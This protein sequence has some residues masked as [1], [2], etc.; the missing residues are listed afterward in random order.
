MLQKKN[1]EEAE[2]VYKVVFRYKQNRDRIWVLN[3]SL[4][5]WDYKLGKDGT[6]NNAGPVG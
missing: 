4:A 5:G 2:Q 1:H 6:I 3:K